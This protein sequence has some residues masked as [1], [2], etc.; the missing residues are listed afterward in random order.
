MALY[1]LIEATAPLTA[2]TRV[3]RKLLSETNIQAEANAA[4]DFPILQ[5]ERSDS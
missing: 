5:T 1:L 2:A 3:A 4:A